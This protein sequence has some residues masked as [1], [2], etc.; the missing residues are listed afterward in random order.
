MLFQVVDTYCME[1]TDFYT[2]MII[3]L[4]PIL[5]ILWIQNL[6]LLMPFSSIATLFTMISV[7]GIFYYI[8]REPLS[9]SHREAIGSLKTI[10]LFF[11]TV[12]FAMETI[13]IVSTGF[14][15]IHHFWM[16]CW[17]NTAQIVKNG[18]YVPICS[19]ASINSYILNL[20]IS[21]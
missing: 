13:G 18:K 9:F 10:P 15:I 1:N 17:P 16:W 7:G 21:E 12:L 5:F 3:S 11:G 20:T 14:Q 19:G 6:K 8:F 2:Y 4:V